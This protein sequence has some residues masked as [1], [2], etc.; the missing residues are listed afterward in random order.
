MRSYNLRILA[1][2]HLLH[3]GGALG[4]DQSSDAV[5]TGRGRGATSV[6]DFRGA[7]VALVCSGLCLEVPD[8]PPCPLA[9]AVCPCLLY[10]VRVRVP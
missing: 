5:A 7:L 10:R 3:G 6:H 8:L 9:G 2:H 1:W 4:G